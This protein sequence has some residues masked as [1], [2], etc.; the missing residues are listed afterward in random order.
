MLVLRL[1]SH[2]EADR[3]QLEVRRLI[4]A[5]DKAVYSPRVLLAGQSRVFGLINKITECIFGEPRSLDR[6]SF[7][8]LLLDRLM[9]GIPA[10]ACRCSAWGKGPESRRDHHDTDAA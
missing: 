10:D 1:G 5:A 3:I 2:H 8:R 7:K 6:F 4:F 9:S